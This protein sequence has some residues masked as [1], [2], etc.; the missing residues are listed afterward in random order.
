VDEADIRR[1]E[2]LA[3]LRLSAAERDALRGDLA[4]ILA[5]VERLGELD[6]EGAPSQ[7]HPR[8][9]AMPRRPDLPRPSLPRDLVLDQA[10]DTVGGHLLGPPLDWQPDAEEEP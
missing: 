8:V 7:S 4:R 9:E 3:G 10:P 5:Y 2:E 1:L 6:L